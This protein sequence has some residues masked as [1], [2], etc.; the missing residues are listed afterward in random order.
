MERIVGLKPEVQK[1]TSVTPVSAAPGVI[2]CDRLKVPTVEQ[3]RNVI[4][5]RAQQC[6]GS[7][8]VAPAVVV[9][10]LGDKPGKSR[11]PSR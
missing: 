2:V 9:V 1:T 6:M 3:R 4:E 11:D 8:G 10:Q 5:D 7:V